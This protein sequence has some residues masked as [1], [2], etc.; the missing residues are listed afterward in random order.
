MQLKHMLVLGAMAALHV[1][2]AAAEP[3]ALGERYAST[4]ASCHGTNG[5][6]LGEIVPGLAGQSRDAIVKAM[7]EFK[8]G[9]RDAT[10]M[11][12]IAKGYSDQQIELVAA[13]FAAQK[14]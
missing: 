11:H 8:T 14:K 6:P 13:Y 7:K 9:K 10:I 3:G 12:Q 5:V 2:A 1:G 4:C